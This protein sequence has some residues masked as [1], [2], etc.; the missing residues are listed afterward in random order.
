MDTGISGKCLVHNI[1]LLAKSKAFNEKTVTAD[2]K[3]VE[4]VVISH[5]HS[6]H[7]NGLK[8]FLNIYPK[9]IPVHV[10][11][12]AFVKRRFK[13]DNGACEP[14]ILFDESS[15]QKLGAI[16]KKKKTPS[17]ITAGLIYVSGQVERTN[18]FEIGS[19]SL[20][21]NIDNKWVTDPFPGPDMDT[22]RS[23]ITEM[24][25]KSPDY[26]IPMHCTG[27]RAI[28]LFSSQMPNQF[29]LNSVGTTYLFNCNCAKTKKSGATKQC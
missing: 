8:T 9:K 28:N 5:G 23:T 14:M 6:D 24:K 18:N 4:S 27:M 16:I 15:I 10:H 7:F 20:E 22:A 3:D 19:L 13:H 29:I 1:N 11:P 2:I 26:V 12:S 21:A 25:K 17:I